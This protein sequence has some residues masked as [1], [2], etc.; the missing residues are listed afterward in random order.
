MGDL[1]IEGP[2]D[3]GKHA[4]LQAYRELCLVQVGIGNVKHRDKFRR[5]LKYE[6]V[7]SNSAS[8]VTMV[9]TLRRSLTHVEHMLHVQKHTQNSPSIQCHASIY[10][11]PRHMVNTCNLC[12]RIRLRYNMYNRQTD[13]E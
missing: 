10:L 7:V 12:N 13:C 9:T 6:N 3:H 5:N 1:K 8:L 11:V 2:L 4:W